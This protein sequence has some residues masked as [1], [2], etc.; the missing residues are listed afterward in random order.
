[1]PTPS[2]RPAATPRYTR[3]GDH[4][5]AVRRPRTLAGRLIVWQV[6]V[7]LL[8]LLGLGV[9]LN[10]VLEG[11]LVDSLTAS[12]TSQARSVRAALPEDPSQLQ[13]TVVRL[14][15]VSDV[16]ITVIR[17][18]GV[19]LADSEHDPAAMENHADRPEV[20]EALQ[21]RT[22]TASR[23]SE[24]VGGEFRYVALP[25]EDGA[26][27]RL[28]VPLTLVRDRQATVRL[29]VAL[30]MLAAAA[31]G[32]I[33]VLLVGRGVSRP[34]RRITASL[35][36][37]G[38]SDVEGR[39]EQ[40]GAEEVTILAAAL[41]RMADRLRNQVRASRE[42]QRARDLIL[43]S[44][45]EGI[46]LAGPDGGVTFA[47]PALERYLGA[48]PD[49]VATLSPAMLRDALRRAREEEAAVPVEVE[50]GV[51]TRSLRGA[52]LPVDRV[53]S[54]LLVLRDVTQAK[55]LDAVRRDF[56]ANASHELKT[57]VAAI[58]AAAE[59][60]R[61]AAADDPAVVPRFT[62]Q[63]EREAV[64][65]SRIVSDLLDLSRLE[66]GTDLT[67]SVALDAV[68]EEEVIRF[69]DI[70]AE[71]KVQ[72]SV[73]AEDTPPIRGSTQDL[74]LLIANLVDNAIQYTRP[75]G[76][77]HVSLTAE[78]AEVVLRVQDTGI[79][80]ASRDLPRIFERFY[81]GDRARSRETGGT[82]LGLSIVKHVAENH[83]G[84][85]RVK[86]ELGR[87]SHFEVR[88]PA[89]GGTGPSPPG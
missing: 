9:V 13:D 82:G 37:L 77:V 23:R 79:G 88:L 52:A 14:G 85:V 68:V 7:V 55:R 24:T 8:V 42:A 45:E 62:E 34:L 22:G 35:A 39:I 61:R 80:I 76:R 5:L 65:L 72:L 21:G 54:V 48:R 27:V 15:R 73:D 75:G 63:L 51:P 32:V 1:M 46:L 57:P 86:S 33:G 29:T 4:E 26:V 25:P 74:R 67:E 83:G 40:G 18:D 38:E 44:M 20:R 41:N 64:R 71:A 43:S 31:A 66:A 53:G 30:G 47:N 84:M 49:R 81:R 3:S 70:A 11:H 50:L 78:D 10:H 59:T 16:R 6:S 89:P 19:V 17:T 56:V 12:L 69:S 60:I 28:A 58:L 2:C 36:R 87:G